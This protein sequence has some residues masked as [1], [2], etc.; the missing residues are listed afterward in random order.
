MIQRAQALWDLTE[1]S[2]KRI[3]GL[4]KRKNTFS[5]DI[6]V[7]LNAITKIKNVLD[8]NLLQN[9]IDN[10]SESLNLNPSMKAVKD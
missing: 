2:A 4:S 9:N 5:W 10:Q 8:Q 3:M 7:L 6:I 1:D